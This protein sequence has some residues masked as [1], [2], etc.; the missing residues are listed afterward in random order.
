MWDYDKND[1]VNDYEYLGSEVF[2][3]VNIWKHSLCWLFSG[4]KL[5]F[6]ATDFDSYLVTIAIYCYCCQYT[7]LRMIAI[8]NVIAKIRQDDISNNPKFIREWSLKYE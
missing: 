2:L 4:I 7:F 1:N 3:K 6:S 5:H 8:K